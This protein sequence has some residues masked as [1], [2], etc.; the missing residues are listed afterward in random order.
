MEEVIVA[1]DDER[2]MKAC[3]QLGINAMLTL[4]THRSGVDRLA[5]VAEKRPLIII[6]SF[7]VMSH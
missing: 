1:T 6:C 5:E 4:V 3:S 2:I 7:K